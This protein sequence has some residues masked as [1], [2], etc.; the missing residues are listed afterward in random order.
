MIFAADNFFWLQPG[1]SRNISI[2]LN[3]REKRDSA[4]KTLVVSSWNAP[5][6]TVALP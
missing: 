6:A 1:E 4:K 5:P 3:W 2:Q